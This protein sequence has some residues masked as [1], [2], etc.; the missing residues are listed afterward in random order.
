MFLDT[1]VFIVVI[2]V[3]ITLGIPIGSYEMEIFA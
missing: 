3:D 1:D 2:V